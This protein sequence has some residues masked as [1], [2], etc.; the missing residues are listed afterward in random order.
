MSATARNF[1][2]GDILSIT[3]CRLVSLRHIEGVYD[4]LNYMTGD[5]L[6]AHQLPRAS[7]ECA[8]WLVR[9]HPAL[10]TVTEA[11][12]AELDRLCDAD[13]GDKVAP[14]AK[15]LTAMKTRYGESLPISPIPRDDHERKDPIAE[16]R[17]MVGSDKTIVIQAGT[18]N[19]TGNRVPTMTL[20]EFA[21]TYG[22]RI[23]V[24][25]RGS[26]RRRGSGKFYAHFLGV[27]VSC[28]EHMLRGA[29]GDGE[30][31][32]EAIAAYAAEIS[33]KQ[34]VVDA[35]S[36]S[37]RE[38]NVPRLVEE[39][40]DDAIDK[41]AA[42]V[43]ADL[44]GDMRRCCDCSGWFDG[45]GPRC[46]VCTE[47]RNPAGPANDLQVLRTAAT[48]AVDAIEAAL[49]ANDTNKAIVPDKVYEGLW[50]AMIGLKR[51]LPKV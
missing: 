22:L 14:V 19:V 29:Y 18:L 30:T 1:D 27:D 50:D 4:I 23:E 13:M 2:L 46:P 44:D 17:E 32:E 31:P 7:R 43:Q 33:E 9:Q 48:T 16:L 41:V 8:S 20:V 15:W 3:T 38:I 49:K 25:E 5:D 37:R 28:G 26:G 21:V 42:G 47:K 24:N 35:M 36:S 10:A 6:F 45:P 34:I 51:E 40:P 11:D 39:S 12:L